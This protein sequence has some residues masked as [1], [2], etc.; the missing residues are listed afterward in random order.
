MAEKM[1]IL[2]LSNIIFPEVSE[3]LGLPRVVV[4]S[5]M[6]A[7]KSL[8]QASHA[9]DMELHVISPYEGTSFADV[10]AG[11]A[12]HYL[13]PETT[14]A[15]ELRK[16]LK[17][18]ND[19]VRPDVVHI[20]GSE[21]PHS[22]LFVEACGSGN[23]ILSIQGLVSVYARYY[24]GGLDLHGK[25]TL[26]DLLKRDT[27]RIQQRDFVRRGRLERSLISRVG[28]IAGRT[29]WDYAHSVAINPDVRYYTC[30]E[31]LRD[32]FYHAAWSLDECH[33]HTIFACQPAYPIK[34][35]HQLLAALPLV[36]RRYPDVHL[37]LPG[38]NIGDRPWWKIRAYWRYINR[39]IERHDLRDCVTFLGGQTEEEMIE[40]YLSAN[41]F[42]CP[43]SIENSSNS[44]CEA[45]ILG[46]PVVASYVGGMMDL[47]ADGESGLLYRFEEVEMLAWKICSIFADDALALRLSQGARAVATRRHDRAAIAESLWAIY[48]S[49]RCTS[50]R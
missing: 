35:L 34:G 33:R 42:V 40:H 20:H 14:G 7:Y 31:P 4:G 43:S 26:R 38:D 37:Y 19:R 27:P 1:R 16:W 32:G 48:Q 44:V 9:A 50:N 8:L 17:A 12:H 10:E 22:S 2:W 25:F 41:V 15:S 24:Y 46:V 28:N 45:Q 18:V 21:Y 5:W 23:A 30:Q 6:M 36:R 49:V 3:R 11:G 29:S 47:V 13:F 39:L